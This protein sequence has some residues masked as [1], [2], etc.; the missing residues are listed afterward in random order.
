L[1]CLILLKFSNGS[2]FIVNGTL[3][4]I[5]TSEYPITF[6]SQSGTTNNSWG[7]LTLSGSGAAGSQLKYAD[8]KYG[9]KIEAINTSNIT[10]QYCNI[11]TTYDG[12]RFNNSTGSIL[13]NNITT[14]SLGHGIVAENAAN[15][16]IKE[17]VITKTYASRCGVGIYFGGGSN[18]IA[19]KNDIYGWDWGVCAIWGSSPISYSSL[20]M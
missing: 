16:T 20:A 1:K 12:I 14:N 9:T 6:S 2:S 4:A 3:N 19:A 11:D 15:V 18:G 10:I 13:N 5:G 17:N 8:I 7:T